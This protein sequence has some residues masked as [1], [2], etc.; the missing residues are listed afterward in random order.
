MQH[1][2]ASEY[3]LVPNRWRSPFLIYAYL[4]IC[5]CIYMY[6]HIYTYTYIGKTGVTADRD[7]ILFRL[8]ESSSIFNITLREELFSFPKQSQIMH[9][10]PGFMALVT[11]VKFLG[12][13]LKA[14]IPLWHNKRVQTSIAEGMDTQYCMC[15]EATLGVFRLGWVKSLETLGTKVVV[16]VFI[17]S[18][19]TWNVSWNLEW[20]SFWTLSSF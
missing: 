8:F 12:E 15:E 18:W 11:W 7:K 13:K 1:F 5:I 16:I 3:F 2:G 20:K 10:C 17:D 6:I 9:S 14:T 19:K 4:C